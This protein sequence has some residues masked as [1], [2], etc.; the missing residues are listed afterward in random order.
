VLKKESENS[1]FNCGVLSHLTSVT[2]ARYTAGLNLP[3][4]T[5]SILHLD[6]WCRTWSIRQWVLCWLAAWV[7]I[8]CQPCLPYFQ[9]VQLTNTSCIRTQKQLLGL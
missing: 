6:F 2:I 4:P 9:A 5:A 1:L 3:S 8:Q 7:S